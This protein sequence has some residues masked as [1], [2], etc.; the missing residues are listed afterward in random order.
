MP[1]FGPLKR[2]DLIV[3]LRRLGFEGPEPGS[4]HSVM[5]RA[6]QR[7]R[8]P[9]PHQVDISR[10]MLARIL[11]QAGIDRDEWEGL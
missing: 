4:K 11:R 6:Q 9:N 5:Y 3:Y 7:E 8:L 10:D 1:R 2:A